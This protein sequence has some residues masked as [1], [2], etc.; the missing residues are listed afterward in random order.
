MFK[1]MTEEGL[2]L[3]P[4]NRYALIDDEEDTDKLKQIYPN[5]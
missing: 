5:G 2:P 3:I 1:W 4:E